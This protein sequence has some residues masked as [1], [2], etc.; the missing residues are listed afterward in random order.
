VDEHTGRVAERRH[1]PDGL[2][3]AV[4]A[5]EGVSTQP[6]GTILG[7]MTMQHF[8]RSYPRLAGMTATARPAADELETFYDLGV[9]VIPTHRPCIRTDHDPVVFTHREAKDR[10]VVTEV[11]RVHRLGRPVLVGTASV[12]ESEELAARL[13]DLGVPCQVLNAANDEHEAE[14]V[15]EA[16]GLGAVTISTNMA[17][18]GTDIRLGGH[19]ETRRQEVVTLGGLYVIG[20]NRH[21]SRRIDLQLAG[22]AGRQGDPG[23][24]RFFISLEDDLMQRFGLR[25]MLPRTLVP[26]RQ[27]EPVSHP[28]LR[29]EIDRTQRVMEGQD[30][31]TRKTLWRYSDV[32]ESQRSFLQ[33][34]RQQL[35]HRQVE[36]E[37]LPA[38]CPDRY[39]RL[40]ETF[41]HDMLTDVERHL[42]LLLTDRCWSDHLGEMAR[43]RDGIH[44]VTLGGKEPYD[45]FHARAREAFERMLTRL[46]DDIVSTFSE[47]EITANGVDWELAGLRGPSSTWTYMVTDTPFEQDPLAGLA[48][49]PAAGAYAA[50]LY[51]PMLIGWGAWRLLQRKW[52]RRRGG[53]AG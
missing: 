23:S 25:S 42:T 36:P 52:Q 13:E 17:G 11:E 45:E 44:L 18:R 38:R 27:D 41:G 20:T 8:L 19:D 29:A 16:G 5:K 50:L 9:V 48:R 51:A 26:A 12:A 1:W 22:R 7:S 40:A 30:F 37:L 43:I 53:R 46:D 15:A 14:I 35:L 2:Q 21:A 6:E 49:R 39:R 47:L 32:I 31:D 33:E 34:W 10:A 3:A 24:S 28:V 4:E